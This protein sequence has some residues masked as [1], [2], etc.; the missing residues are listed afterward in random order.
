MLSSGGC[1][2]ASGHGCGVCC[3][4]SSLLVGG[5]SGA[6]RGHLGLCLHRLLPPL[7]P[8]TIHI[9]LAL[10]NLSLVAPVRIPVRVECCADATRARKISLSAV[11]EVFQKLQAPATGPA[12]IVLDDD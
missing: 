12:A 11:L 7:L 4:A 6:S 3:H 2:L 1:M 10:Q 8:D 9:P 5:I